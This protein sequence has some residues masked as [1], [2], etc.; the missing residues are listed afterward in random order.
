MPRLFCLFNPFNRLCAVTVL[1]LFFHVGGVVRGGDVTF[2][3]DLNVRL[4]C[5]PLAASHVRELLLQCETRLDKTLARSRGRGNRWLSIFIL[6]PGE[7][8][9]SLPPMGKNVVIT[10]DASDDMIVFC[11]LR[12]LIARRLEAPDKTL[13]YFDWV[14]AAAVFDILHVRDMNGMLRPNYRVIKDALTHESPPSP[15]DLARCSISPEFPN[16][17]LLFATWSHLYQSLLDQLPAGNESGLM[18][19]ARAVDRGALPENAWRATWRKCGAG[20]QTSTQWLA[21]K[22]RGLANRYSKDQT[23]VTDVMCELNDILEVSVIIPGPNGEM[24]YRKIPIRNL[25]NQLPEVRLDEG[26]LQVMENKIFSLLKRVPLTLQGPLANFMAAFQ[27][28]RKGL[29][30]GKFL[31]RIEKA[32]ADLEGAMERYQGIL[33]MLDDVEKQYGTSTSSLLPAL[34]VSVEQAIRTRSLDPD[35]SRFLDSFALG[36]P[37]PDSP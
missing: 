22:S 28:Q 29:S 33:A 32:E 35:V 34:R 11:C 14:A 10:S 1:C 16:V 17:F 13:R 36:I 15:G 24:A 4:Y 6:T 23:A 9:P 27:E 25:K 21:E 30:W 12:G 26:T 19:F 5:E 7:K 2:I 8:P 37:A 3:N 20:D 18:L 31:S